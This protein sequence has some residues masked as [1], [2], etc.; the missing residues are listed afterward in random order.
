MVSI[1]TCT[2]P[3]DFKLLPECHQQRP[4]LPENNK[5]KP[6]HTI[7]KLRKAGLWYLLLLAFCR[8][9][10]LSAFCEKV[11]F[12]SDFCIRCRAWQDA[13]EPPV[14]RSREAD[15]AIRGED[16]PIQTAQY[17]TMQIIQH[18]QCNKVQY[19]LQTY[20]TATHQSQR[21]LCGLRIWIPLMT[22]R[23]QKNGG[24]T[25]GNSKTDY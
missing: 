17:N 9:H 8:T 7:E 25:V 16:S 6:K 11:H 18:R 22:R 15:N 23:C 2:G 4:E 14:K 1:I 21:A 5:K 13:C 12:L 10:H 3:W 20:N 24:K 19:R